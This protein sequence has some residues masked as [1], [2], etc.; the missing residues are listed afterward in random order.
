MSTSLKALRVRPIS[1]LHI[2]SAGH[3]LGP[4]DLLAD[5]D[6]LVK[7]DL[8]AFVRR[9]GLAE[10]ALFESHLRSEDGLREGHRFMAERLAMCRV[11]ALPVGQLTPASSA[12]LTEFL[13]GRMRAFRLAH[14]ALQTGEATVLNG[15]HLRA[16]L[17]TG[18]SR[19]TSMQ[20]IRRGPVDA[21]WRGV[22]FGAVR[23]TAGSFSSRIALAG[24]IAPAASRPLVFVSRQDWLQVQR[25]S[26]DAVM[27]V[28]L[29][30]MAAPNLR[31]SIDAWWALQLATGPQAAKD[32][33]KALSGLAHGQS[34]QAQTEG[35]RFVARAQAVLDGFDP[36]RAVLAR[37]GVGGGLAHRPAK[38]PSRPTHGTVPAAVYAHRGRNGRASLPDAAPLGWVLI[39]AT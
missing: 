31:A 16:A 29:H 6:A 8:D 17:V 22:S 10:R 26:D 27:Q 19:Q 37:I 32:L 24:R 13:S 4:L 36:Q 12:A 35:A 38:A 34:Q 3:T 7:V 28:E 30:P 25:P 23:L 15:G 14:A 9:L 1:P 20:P 2:G 21:P 33:A 11:G 39:E 18:L 5:G